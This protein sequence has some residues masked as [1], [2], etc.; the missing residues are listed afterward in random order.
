MVPY[1]SLLFGPRDGYL[2]EMDVSNSRG[3]RL[4]SD[5]MEGAIGAVKALLYLAALT[6]NIAIVAGR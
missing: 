5:L 1:D 4:P 2:C 3:G 6:W